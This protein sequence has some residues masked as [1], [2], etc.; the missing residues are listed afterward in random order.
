MPVLDLSDTAAVK[1]YEEFVQHSPYGQVGQDLGWAKIKNNWEP[2]YAYVT[3]EAGNIIAAISM[4]LT[5]TKLGKKFAY[6]SKG[7]VMDITNLDLLEQL[8][9]EAKKALADDDA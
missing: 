6:A 2:R 4:L 7:P 9:T 3:D 8:M 5:Q 1:K